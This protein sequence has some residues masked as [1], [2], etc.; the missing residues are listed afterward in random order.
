MGFGLLKASPKTKTHQAQERGWEGFSQEGR[1]DND[2][3]DEKKQA[4]LGCL[5]LKF[6]QRPCCSELWKGTN[7]YYE[8]QNSLLYK[9]YPEELGCLQHLDN[10]QAG[11]NSSTA[12]RNDQVYNLWS[13]HRA[14]MPRY[15]IAPQEQRCLGSS[16]GSNQR[17][18]IAHLQSPPLGRPLL[19]PAVPPQGRLTWGKHLGSSAWSSQ[20]SQSQPL[21]PPPSS[22][23]S[24]ST[25]LIHLYWQDPPRSKKQKHNSHQLKPKMSSLTQWKEQLTQEKMLLNQRKECKFKLLHDSVSVGQAFIRRELLLWAYKNHTCPLLHSVTSHR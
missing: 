1:A 6:S 5:L 23:I 20:L 8:K 7:D 25:V 15:K 24:N 16:G 4:H 11:V 9:S 17:K 18:K 3:S 19:R 21:P 14:S 13:I 2:S 22:L 12:W 10:S